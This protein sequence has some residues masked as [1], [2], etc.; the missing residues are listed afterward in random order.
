[1]RI[2]E[3]VRATGNPKNVVID[4]D[5]VHLTDADGAD[6]LIQLAEELA[7]DDISIALAAVHPPVLA[8]WRRAAVF[9]AVDADSVYETV[10]KAIE[11]VS[12]RDPRFIPIG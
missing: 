6:I 11:A 2:H 10:E 3:L 1:M 7:A 5:A 12:R 4:V 9:D 8:L